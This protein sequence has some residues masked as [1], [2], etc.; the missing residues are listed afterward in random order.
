MSTTNEDCF[1]SGKAV[2]ASGIPRSEIFI[3]TKL[4]GGRGYEDTV[5]S[6]DSSLKALDMDYID[7]LLIHDAFSG[8]RHDHGGGAYFQAGRSKCLRLDGDG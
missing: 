7:L 1:S 4:W 2:K 5:S 6:I 3:T 8:Q